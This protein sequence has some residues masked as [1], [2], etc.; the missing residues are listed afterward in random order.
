M[1]MIHDITYLLTQVILKTTKTNVQGRHLHLCTSKI[2]NWMSDNW[3]KLNAEKTEFLIAGTR[4]QHSKVTANSLWLVIGIDIK[5]SV[6]VKN[7]GVIIDQDLS[8]KEQVN[9]VC[10]SCYRHLRSVIQIRPYLTKSA[11]HTIVQSLISSRL[12]YCN[13]LHG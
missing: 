7:L 3:L 8:V 13:S 10:R 5:P 4:R 12:V 11:A 6:N 2:S 9:A 1:L